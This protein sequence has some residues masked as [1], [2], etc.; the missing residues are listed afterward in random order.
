MI[1][2]SW[3]IL[4]GTLQFFRY[5]CWF[6]SATLRQTSPAHVLCLIVL[7]LL[8]FYNQ[9]LH[10][11]RKVGMYRPLLKKIC[12]YQRVWGFE[13]LQLAPNFWKQNVPCMK[14]AWSCTLVLSLGIDSAGISGS[15]PNQ[16]LFL[17]MFPS[18]TNLF[19]LHYAYFHLCANENTRLFQGAAWKV[20]ESF[21]HLSE[22]LQAIWCL[23][24]RVAV[25]DCRVCVCV[26]RERE[27][28]RVFLLVIPLW[29]CQ[30]VW[31]GL[32]CS[33]TRKKASQALT[34]CFDQASSLKTVLSPWKKIIFL[35]SIVCSPL[36]QVTHKISCQWR[37]FSIFPC[38]TLCT[39]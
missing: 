9:R 31:S 17:F 12:L 15:W 32:V 25:K 26:Y 20:S 5:C 10:L 11:S 28:E 23:L 27:R 24:W 29:D 14:W 21:G 13:E 38:F 7:I 35:L 30:T 6:T 36:S 16:N 39:G 8:L 18:E 19:S 2:V 4:D 3:A 37:N 22:I 33:A 34:M 1:G